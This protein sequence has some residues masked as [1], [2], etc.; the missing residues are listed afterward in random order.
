MQNSK[1]EYDDP[2]RQQNAWN[3]HCSARSK[4]RMHDNKHHG[5]LD[6]NILRNFLSTM[7]Q[8]KLVN[9]KPPARR[10]CF[11]HLRDAFCITVTK[12]FRALAI[13]QKG[14]S[15]E[16]SKM[17]LLSSPSTVPATRTISA[18]AKCYWYCHYCCYHAIATTA[19]ADACHAHHFC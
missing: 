1:R 4:P 15:C 3:V 8:P 13:C 10:A 9:C 18:A 16:T 5:K 19:I 11:S 7:I 2:A 12:T 14:I 6:R 17:K